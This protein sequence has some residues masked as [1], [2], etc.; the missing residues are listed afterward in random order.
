MT[1]SPASIQF[2]L[3]SSFEYEKIDEQS[4]EVSFK[5]FTKWWW[6]SK[7]K[8]VTK[9][10]AAGGAIFTDETKSECFPV[11]PSFPFLNLILID[12]M[13]QL[14]QAESKELEKPSGDKKFLNFA[15]K[16]FRLTLRSN[17]EMRRYPFDRHIV[18]AMLALRR[19]RADDGT[20]HAWELLPKR[21]DE[22]FVGK[23]AYGE[24][25]QS[26]NLIDTWTDAHDELKK[27]REDLKPEV[28]ILVSRKG[29]KGKP[30]LC[31]KLERDPSAFYAN[32]A[33]PTFITVSIV[34]MS[35]F[36]RDGADIASVATGILTLMASQVALQA[37]L[38]KTVYI[39]YAGWYLLVTY[40]FL[41]FLGLGLTLIERI[42]PD[43]DMNILDYDGALWIIIA[44]T[45]LWGA[46][47]LF[48]FLDYT[49]FPGFVFL[50]GMFRESWKDCV[51]GEKFVYGKPEHNEIMEAGSHLIIN[52]TSL[53]PNY[54]TV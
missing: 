22:W 53:F 47:H 54:G 29:K 30:V 11:N 5:T 41:F 52:R 4:G 39:T 45:V 42:T 1:S 7:E 43:K 12:N 18:P 25:K 31:L 50:R 24:D 19:W 10:N 28:R 35:F 20:D 38:P 36:S 8:L 2:W 23:K 16:V 51:P 33:L 17:L 32:I 3:V 48:A 21:P 6:H 9:K 46:L 34:L 14:A 40:M 37:K 26:V 15:Q 49:G 44:F 27:F 13:E